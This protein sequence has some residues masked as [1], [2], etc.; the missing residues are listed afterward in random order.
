[1]AGV[2]AV[3]AAAG[4]G[5]RMGG[6]ISKVLLPLGERP[7]LWWT[8][9]AFEES[10][11]VDAVCLVANSE[12][13]EEARRWAF[14]KLRL[15]V[16]GAETRGASV[17]RGL[18]ALPDDA[19]LAVLH[20]GARPCVTVETIAAVVAAARETGGAAVGVPVRDTIQEVDERLEVVHTPRRD[21]L[22]AV[23]TPQVFYASAI[24]DAYRRAAQAGFEATDDAAVAR[25]AGIP[26]R[27]VA[28]S[29]DNI[30]ITVPGDLTAA[31]RILAV[32]TGRPPVPRT[33][34]GIDTHRLVPDRALVLGG[35][36]VPYE[37]G[38]LGHS[39]ADALAHAVMD[40]L[41]GAA[42]LGDIGRHF[43]DT[44]ERYRGADSLAL[45]REVCAMLRTAGYRPA[46]V[47]AVVIAQRPRL[48]PYID[49]MRDRL[50][51]AM[52][53]SADRVSVKATTTEGLGPEGRGECVTVHA[54][55]MI[56]P[57]GR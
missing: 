13:M 10:G 48:A 26:V 50:A 5:A 23:Q 37:M 18:E 56:V 28:G 42:S 34:I 17:L 11:D 51:G 27:L 38:L 43:P 33:G 41:L 19:D 4:R 14:P 15:I 44:D 12:V 32:R 57:N 21:R 46:G 24:R 35:V 53:L 16:P 6:P 47:D 31:E 55:A 20:D 49:E 7:A 3:I 36:T 1:M 25:F 54:V 39:D 40:A 29:E 8:L 22:W 9:S 2:W 30:K 52:G 45:L